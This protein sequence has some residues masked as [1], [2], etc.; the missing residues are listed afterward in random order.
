MQTSELRICTQCGWHAYLSAHARIAAL[1][2]PDSFV[3]LDADLGSTD[4][5]HFSSGASYAALLNE[6]RASTGLRDAVVSGMATLQGCPI[7]IVAFDFRF[8]GG[9][10]GAAVGEKIARAFEHAIESQRALIIVTSS[11]G[12]RIQEGMLALMQMAKTAAATQRLHQ[13]GLPYFS[14]LA[15]PT[16]GGVYASF[17]T[18]ADVI[19]AE[20]GALIG[21]AGPRVVKALTSEALP[22]DSHTAEFQ[23]RNGMIDL[24][25]DRRDLRILLGRLL[26]FSGRPARIPRALPAQRRA[27]PRPRRPLFNLAWERVRR[28]RRPDRPSARAY[29]DLIFND[30]IELHGD[31]Q[32]GEDAS[33][34]GGPAWLADRRAMVI[35]QDRSARKSIDPSGFY[36]SQRLMKLAA[37]YQLPVITFID[38]IGANPQVDSEAHG[39]ARAIAANLELMAALPVPTISVVIGEGGSGGALALGLTDRVLM[40]TNAFY[41]VIS[42][43]G[44]ASILLRDPRQARRIVAGLRLTSW[45]LQKLGI[46]DRVLAEPHDGAHRDPA[47][48]A[49]TIEKVLHEELDALGKMPIEALLE[50]RYQKYRA[51]GN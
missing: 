40:Q 21:F 47:A 28:T 14:V 10:M 13:A 37:K 6:A 23:F 30:F 11:G 18:L 48:A 29:I 45:D 25:V 8:I 24:I 44:A 34:C 41:S 43:E 19:V 22:P 50:K 38:T 12:A 36:K 4:R 20:P 17:A 26:A 3:E 46:I 1:V 33:I 7:V 42:P 32:S 39:V 35:G 9:S 5:L 16:S 31:R 15:H 27:L 49:A 2:D 51:I